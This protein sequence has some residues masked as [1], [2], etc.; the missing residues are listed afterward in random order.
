MVP[1]T[2]DTTRLPLPIPRTNAFGDEVAQSPLFLAPPSNIEQVVEYDPVSKQYVVYERVGNYNISQ[3][4]VMSLE[5]YRAY[6][7]DKA[8]RT[9]WKQK[10]T[11]ETMGKGD[12]ILPKFQIGGESFDRIFG[13][14][15]IEIIPQGSAELLFGVTSSKTENPSLP[16][17][18][19]RNT[20]FDFQSKIQMNVTGKIGEKL[21][22]EV[23][24]NTE[25][26]F[27]FENNVKV[28]YNGTED[29][30]IQRIEAG[31]VSL[32]LP[33][34]LITG[35]QSLFG[36]KTK[37][38]FGKLDVTSV[39]SKQN[40]QTQVIE[41]KG[42]AQVRDFE[43]KADEYDAN[44]HFFL[45]HYFRDNY[46]QA[47]ASLPIVNSRVSIT[48]IEVWVT[49]RQA[50]F[51][52]SRNILAFTDLGEAAPHIFA[53]SVVTA[54]GV[55]PT[56]NGRN[57]LYSLMTT[58]YAGIRDVSQINSTLSPL[59]AMG[60][61]GG[62][63]YEKIEYARK[64]STNEYTLN[65]TLGYIS[66]SSTL[67][68]DEVLAVAF[69][70]TLD[71][72]TYKVGEFST[73]GVS[74]PQTLI[75]KLLKGTNLSPSIYTW[76][77]MMKN[78]YT[79]NAY[80]VSKDN[81]IM[82]ILYQ[83]DE[84]GTPLNYI[85]EGA[86]ANRPLI[87]VLNL[88]NVNSQGDASPDGVFD[89]TDGITINAASGKIIF[90]VLEPF[91]RDLRARINNSSIAN[92]YVYEELYDSTLT[93]AR[94]VADK[95]KFIMRG[96]YQSTGGSEIYLNAMN[97]PKGS[98]VVTAGGAQLVEDVQFIVDY[99]LG[100]VR[101]IDQGLLESGTTI[102]VSV[103]SNALYNLQTKT[104]VGSHFNYQFSDNFNVGA[105]IMNLTERPLTQKVSFGNEAIS[106]TIWGLN[107]S[108]QTESKF[109]TKVVD[110]LPFIETKERSTLTFDAEFAHFIPGSAKATGGRVYLDDFE[111]SSTSIDIHSWVDWKLSSTPQGQVALFPE[112]SLN[113]DLRYGYNRARLAW[114]YID[115][116]F[117]RN[118]S[119]TPGYMR[120]NDKYQGS[121]WV[122][123]IYE[124]EI[125]PNKSTVQGQPT[126]IS[127]LNMAFYPNE[128]GPYNYDFQNIEV[129]GKLQNP[130]NR[131]AGIT[132]S[133]STT[134]FETSNVE[135]VEFWLMDPFVYNP[136]A[137]GGDFYINL[138]NISEDVLKDGRKSFENGLPTTAAMEKTDSTVWG[139]VPTGQYLPIGFDNDEGKRKYQD[140]GYDGL[141]GVDL[142][143]DGVPDEYSFFQDYVSQ[144][145]GRV[146][147]DEFISAVENDPSADDFKYYLNNEYDQL[148]ASILDRYKYFNNTEG[149]SP[150]ATS[151]SSSQSYSTPDVEELGADITMNENEAYYQYRIS[152]R[153][154]DMVVGTNYITDVIT[155]EKDKVANVPVKWY[156]F[157]VPVSEY[158]KV[159]GSIDD[160][161][162]IRFMRMLLRGFSDT[163][164]LRFAT[165]E[166]VR[167]EWRKYN[168]ELIEGQEGMP[169]SDLSN[170]SLSISTVNIEENSKRTPVNYILPPGV[171][172]VVD[173]SQTQITELNE[174]AMEFKVEG[175]ADGDARAAFKN[176]N[177]DIRQYR[178][179]KMDVH[180]EM[181]EGYDLDDNEIT[182]FIRLGTDYTNNY[183]EYEVPLKLTPHRSNYNNS[184][185]ADREIVW[186]R[187][188]LF[189]INLDDLVDVKL[190][191]NREMKK[192]G[193][194]IT[195]NTV[196]K[197]MNGANTLKVTGNPNLSNVKVIMI[198]VRNPGK[199]DDS[200]DDG[201]TK[202]VIAWFNEFRL[203]N[204]NDQGGYAANAR[205]SAKMADLGTVTL[206]GSMYTPGFGS[207]EKKVN[208]RSM[209]NHYEYDAN[210]SMELGKFFPEKSN[211]KIPMYAGYSE[212]VS[213]PQY[214]P[215]DPDVLMTESLKDMTS[216]ERDS[217]KNLVQDYSRRR[218]INFTNVKIDKQSSK[219]HFWDISNFA[220]SYSYSELYSRD[221]N[222]DHKIQRAVRGAIT[223]NYNRQT[224]YI[225][226]FKK[227]SWMNSKYLR[228]IKDFNFSLF[229]SQIS[230]RTDVDRNYFEQ[231]TRNIKN[232]DEILNPTYSK[233][234]QWNRNFTMNWDVT[235]A[236]KFDFVASNSARIDEPEG[237]VD[238]RR[239]P[240]NYQHWRDSVWRNFLNLGRNTL[241]NHQFNLTYSLP[242]NKIPFLD[243]T[244]TTARY[245]GTYRWEAGSVL[246]DT[247]AFDPGNKIQNTN[248]IQLNGQLNLTNLFNKS[249]FLKRINQKF[250]QRARG[251]APK[252]R[253][254]KYE[255]EGVN[256]RA[257]VAKSITHKLK[258]DKVT[259]KVYDEQGKQIKV[260]VDIKTDQRITIKSDQAQKGCRVLVEGK[261]PEKMT[262][263]QYVAEGS[264]RLLM[265]VKTFSISYSETNGT[266]LPGFKP[267]S[268]FLGIDSYNGFTTPGWDFVF[269]MQDPDFAWKAAQNGWL[270]RDTSFNTPA[271]FSHTEN[272]SFRSTIEPVPGFKIDIIANRMFAR[273][274]T[275]TFRS[276]VTGAYTIFSPITNGNFSI[277]VISLGTAFEGKNR[278][279]RSEAFQQMKNNRIIIAKRLSNSRVASGAHGYTPG[280][281]DPATS[282]PVGYG[283][284]SQDVLRASFLAAYTNRSA[285]SVTL[286]DFPAIP[287]PNWQLTYDGLAKLKPF[288]NYF[289]TFTLTHGYRSLY[290]IGSYSTNLSYEE[291]N[292]GF[293]YARNLTGDF[294]PMRE[295][296]NVSINEQF[297]PLIGVDVGWQSGLTSR[298][299]VKTSRS[300]A[301]SFSS[302]QLTEIFG[303]E[304]IVGAGYRFENLPLIFESESGDKKALKSDLKVTLD[305][306]LRDNT[307]VLR[308]I[309]DDS[310]ETTSGQLISTIKA[311][312]D[313][314]ISDQV[315]LRFY[316]D[317]VVNAP[318]VSTTYRT[319]NSSFGFS[320][321][322][323]MVK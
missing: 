181:I 206:A 233:D 63:D 100:T 132:R 39:V 283:P 171:T 194:R 307:T 288:K 216:S 5:E 201:L 205:V 207:I 8:M 33:G 42:G 228:I 92:R 55:G 272:L 64:L 261:V 318:K 182:A 158:E 275:E 9:Y 282:Y 49:N 53:P 280:E 161:K 278:A 259:V 316:F 195:F 151:T 258:S 168:Y 218:S 95:N 52:N 56:D 157:K 230:F 15:T 250:D 204:F 115:P 10:Q 297:S 101:I 30:I 17:D 130:Q 108:F 221:I 268:R 25:A 241:Y 177:V 274:R 81:F 73:D 7:V 199:S 6:R 193:S 109:L 304:Y 143:G 82:N 276:D 217:L 313:Y 309:V 200:D 32:P 319:T 21:K 88:D 36:F 311:S 65:A 93:K 41:I 198:G 285:S 244:S 305:F 183:Y 255:Q 197:V 75:L 248:A 72:Q 128:R 163:L 279:E 196:Y 156:Q 69:E 296:T 287:M 149:N 51:E 147:S 96:S 231:Q 89:F 22:M 235:Q 202:S 320:V 284:L 37:L 136:D 245:S 24:Y 227:V 38:K 240:E 264:V 60:F 59:N 185:E 66:L 269:G 121:H 186:P 237:M 107:T 224:K 111:G 141:S 167:G 90:P 154:E 257:N 184:R 170:A 28:E 70:Y 29:E 308:Q 303:N 209:E 232:P 87:Q 139:R 68:T 234:F 48:K 58:T 16:V 238:R 236:M 322:F 159:V 166:L 145:R 13:S 210:T 11:G 239:D 124:K 35:S 286:S 19:R 94:Q 262:L 203:S 251:A 213:N 77:L 144:I 180:A 47:L 190:E 271:V 119:S 155:G 102:T 4:R 164:I 263:L 314:R 67:N 133:L 123:E 148:K 153:P 191:R 220:L 173:P 122:R 27:D 45:S 1:F 125:F 131:W 127:V 266:L 187:E 117:L 321:R 223:Y 225:T 91:G 98:V 295:I 152:L 256:L 211:V 71:G 135:Y 105:T 246:N 114:Y 120:S 46:N 300:L 83:N 14:N 97:I 294:Y 85:A 26:T 20:T 306:S 54:T 160:F 140:I 174:Q 302:T 43:L 189:N 134:D 293:S 129:D 18:Q 215:L 317:R 291:E 281:I 179:L 106:N 292:D 172:R 214:N 86:I 138:G 126:N 74:A 212:S 249:G 146:T 57:N 50:N 162:S 229:P 175:L 104:L 118:T 44:R 222:T 208:E 298:L 252:T 34:T 150:V 12:G 40:G 3:P 79:M 273:N 61:D 165:L 2:Q 270:T 112:A 142:D 301:M 226:P 178:N 219:P 299:E 315:T 188:N 277:S 116:L 31:N 80:Q 260:T 137:E 265:S 99:N 62:R 76:D 242:L 289:K 247:S 176:V 323:E 267:G 23:N 113:N 169:T 78:I 84:T 310:N 243:W 103:E 254:V 290:T 312:A 110:W 192:S 253:T